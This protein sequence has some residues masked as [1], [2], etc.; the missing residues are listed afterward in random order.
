MGTYKL[1]A[2]SDEVV[3]LRIGMDMIL[4]E[5]AKLHTLG[6]AE[7]LKRALSRIN[8][9]DEYSVKTVMRDEQGN[10]H[11]KSDASG[12]IIQIFEDG[13]LLFTVYK[14]RRDSVV[15]VDA[16]PYTLMYEAQLKNE[17]VAQAEAIVME[18]QWKHDNLMIARQLRKEQRWNARAI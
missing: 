12:G 11:I 4:R 13:E 9:Y 16:D 18:D 7:F 15:K 2:K 5:G 3:K 8:R 17:V 6:N 1:Y 14:D 10:K